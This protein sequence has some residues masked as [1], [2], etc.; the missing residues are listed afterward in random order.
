MIK[1]IAVAGTMGSG[2][3]SLVRFLCNRYPD[4]RPF[5]EQNEENPY[6]HDFYQDMPRWAFHSQV[7]FLTLKYRTHQQL[8]ASDQVVIQ[9]R[10]IYEDAEIFAEN[11]HRQGH[12]TGRDYEAYRRLYETILEDLNPPDL[13]IYLKTNLR[14][15]KKRIRLRGRE[16]E[17]SVDP[18]YL[19]SLNLLYKRW[20]KKY[21]QSPVL[22]IDADRL[23]FLNDMVDRIELLE[24]IEKHI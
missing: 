23:D 16:Y 7:Y 6:L 2:K 8:Q 9:D 11:L 4:I 24:T 22:V 19:K 20:L 17:S 1:Y 10:T 21:D 14:T 13:L 15:V 12:L 5:Y 3:S 18:E